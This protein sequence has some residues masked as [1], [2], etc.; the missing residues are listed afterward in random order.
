MK[1]QLLHHYTQLADTYD[2]TWGH[3][4]EYV[5]WMAQHLQRRLH[6]RSGQWIGDIGAGTGLFLRR[7]L[8]YATERTPMVC[9][10]PFAAML[11]RLPEDPR[12]CP[13]QAS[14]EELAAGSVELPNPTFDAL[15]IKEA[16]H[17]FNDLDDTLKGLA[18]LLAPGGRMLIVT[19]PPKL[20]YPLFPAARDRFAAGQ[21][22]PEAV[23]DALGRA[24]L[25]VTTEVEEF[26]VSVDRE[27]WL[28]LVAN[29]WMSVLSTFSDEEMESG[30]AEIAEQ[31]PDPR[32]EFTDRF[33]FI[34]AQREER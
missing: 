20:D 8:P 16:V 9:I 24:G 32:L 29:R 17:H 22:E 31:H 23:A 7:L 3:R 1:D 27:H 30:L 33:A 14:A 26:T 11:A 12:L 21:P 19:L 25:T 18:G 4:P 28:R 6:L 34:L 13:V 10:D 15:L 5:E 2:D